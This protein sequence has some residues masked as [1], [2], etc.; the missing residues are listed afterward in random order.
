ME[1]HQRISPDY[2]FEVSWEVCNKVGG[3][4]T[5]L[6]SKTPSMIS[7]F[8]DRFILLGPDVWRGSGKNPDFSEDPSLFSDWKDRA[9]SQGWKIRIGRWNIPEQPLVILLDFS[10]QLAR[11]N[12]IFS[13]LYQQFGLD[14][15]TGGWDYI[16]PALFGFVA[17]QV[18]G[19]FH[20]FYLTEQDKVVAHFHEWL[21]GAG[22]LVL[23]R[24]LPA[25]ATV[26]TTH[27]T[28]LGRAIAGSGQAFYSLLANLKGDQDASELNLRSKHSLERIAAREADCFTTVSPLT[29][30][31]CR[32][33]LQRDPD[34]ITPNGLS[35]RLIPDPDPWV[36]KRIKAR[37]RL[38]EIASAALGKNY[39]ESCFLIASSGR[40]EFHN[41]GLDLFIR[42]LAGLAS[43][44][45]LSRE[46]LAFL[47]IPAGH[48]G[49]RKELLDRLANPGLPREEEL[50]STHYLQNE[51][52]DP[53]LLAL[54]Q[55]DLIRKGSP[56]LRVLFAPVYLDGR[57]GV[58]DLSYYDL[59]AGLDLSLFPSYYE[60]WGYTPQES[61]LFRV[62]SLTSTCAGFGRWMLSQSRDLGKSLI[63]LHRDDNNSDQAAANLEQH[64]R[65]FLDIREDALESIRVQARNLG[66]TTL[67][68]TLF[69]YYLDAW[70]K[71]LGK[72]SDRTDLIRARMKTRESV[73]EIRIQAPVANIPKWKKV[74][75]APR[76]PVAFAGLEDLCRN[77]WW[78]WN[79]EAQD[80]FR[81]LDPVLWEE[82]AH[83]PLELL[84]SLPAH[85]YEELE[86]DTVFM[87]R[88]GGV[89]ERFTSYRG[90]PMQSGQPLVAYFCLEFGLHASLKLYAGG[91]GILAGDFLKEASDSG[92]PLAGV[93]L[94]YQ[95]GYLKQRLDHEQGQV[96]EPD[97]NKFTRLPLKP[98]RNEKNEWIYVELPLPGR[99][100]FA[101]IW[102]V[103]IGRVCLY[104]LD[105]DIPENRESDRLITDRLYGGD[106]EHRLLQE[107]LLG[108]G[109]IRLL[110]LLGLKPGVFH[111]NEGHA[112]FC[113]LERLGGYIQGDH[114][115]Y[116]EALEMVRANSLFTTHTPLG[117]ANDRFSE[118]LIRGYFSHY[119]SLFQISW[120][121]FMG[122]GREDPADKGA[123]FG[124]NILAARLCGTMNSVSLPHEG[125]TRRL[126]H[127]LWKGYQPE[128]L[129]IGHITNGV[130]LQT[131]MA[132]Q[133]K[134][135]LNPPVAEV[136]WTEKIKS[137]SP[138]RI[139]GIRKELKLELITV[140]KARLG[141]QV[142]RGW[143]NPGLAFR[144]FDQ[145]QPQTLLLGFARR[146]TSYKRPELLFADLGRL[147]SLFRNPLG[148]VVLILA[149]KAHP[150]D[151]EGLS[152][153]REIL[154]YCERSELAGHILFL[155]NYDMELAAQLVRGVD[156]WLNTPRKDREACATSGMKASLNGVLQL[157]SAEGWWA[158]AFREGTGWSL[159][160]PTSSRDEAAQDALDASLL[161]QVLEEEILPLYFQSTDKLLAP[162]WIERIRKT[163]ALFG[164]EYSSQR[165]LNQ[166]EGQYYRNLAARISRLG[167][168]NYTLARNLAEW[169]TQIVDAWNLIQVRN[170]KIRDF[171]HHQLPMGEPF[172]AELIL[173][174]GKLGP[175]DIAAEVVFAKKDP[176]GENRV[177]FVRSMDIQALSGSEFRYYCRI[178][179]DFPG[180]YQYG[181]RIIP[182]NPELPGRQDF[183][184]V[185]WI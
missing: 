64:I 164:S 150:G 120:E 167:A 46:V 119:I 160:A 107:I 32:K 34:P 52:E 77:L 54:K 145:L 126:Y 67:W 23:R 177:S 147:A 5:V 33:F 7:L 70:N 12:E 141:R 49:P 104:L 21:S 72:L 36:Q 181:I 51:R 95:F 121:Q 9:I 129:N 83:N 105:T 116:L 149:G 183:A 184:L 8:G 18:I 75:I 42:A 26:F 80:L 57:D 169:K 29:A 156:L 87:G 99:N 162:G 163:L 74:F 157:S 69:S 124:L 38:L 40:Y 173:D 31:E 171:E 59:L 159:T 13:E 15:L 165:M 97:E 166:Y 27:A 4:H 30:L 19:S 44:P 151:P 134:E 125:V 128:E 127:G 108:V 22:I 113:G 20:E 133:W 63:I 100:L 76:I 158:E 25:V 98:V 45:T 48:T 154:A 62:P 111:L 28:V 146:V 122:L 139:S 58:F 96:G 161:Y 47:F 92:L 37:R 143:K 41:K 73:R 185:R 35:E 144:V 138:E 132:P 179:P 110:G 103:D 17:G 153:I 180:V 3:I 135:A 85:R 14:S 71:A 50:P 152:Q 130:H 2:L 55:Q 66:R 86:R 68:G 16:N 148:S 123:A 112:A 175:G 78:S 174:L 53:I 131:W 94:L 56:G 114:L 11:K 182:S 24:E 1:A 61:L 136:A 168:D 106:A 91:L 115:S 39:D 6:V 176:G 101:K 89:L 90:L 43:G 102:Q 109:G 172:E 155:E 65:E 140:L 118:E 60:P 170:L 142:D 117:A 88:L 93:G 79:P 81:D 82:S 84:F 10:P 178:T 137:L